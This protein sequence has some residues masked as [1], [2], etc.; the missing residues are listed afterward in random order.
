MRTV[1]KKTEYCCPASQRRLTNSRRSIFFARLVAVN[2][3][4]TL[5]ELGSYH[6]VGSTRAIANSACS[7]E[8]PHVTRFLIR[9][10]PEARA[11]R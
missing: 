2:I 7:D 4:V 10:L 8:L 6:A 3:S 1:G 5:P 11:P 9:Q